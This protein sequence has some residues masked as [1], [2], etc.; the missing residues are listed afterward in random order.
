[1]GQD[2]MSHK[3]CVVVKVP[4]EYVNLYGLPTARCRQVIMP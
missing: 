2:K 4:V 1:M 3:E